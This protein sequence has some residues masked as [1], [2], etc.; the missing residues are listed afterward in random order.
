MARG[1]GSFVVAPCNEAAS[2]SRLLPVLTGRSPI[3]TAITVVN[4]GRIKPEP[5]C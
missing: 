3:K 2:K 4:Y 5:V 1:L